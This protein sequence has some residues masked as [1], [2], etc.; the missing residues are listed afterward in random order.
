MQPIKAALE[1]KY[2]LNIV[3]KV[4]E[5]DAREVEVSHEAW[6]K[7]NLPTLRRTRS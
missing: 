2:K 4:Q 6:F 7:K 5:C 1:I 3:L